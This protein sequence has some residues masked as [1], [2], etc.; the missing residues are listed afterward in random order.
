MKLNQKQ[1]YGIFILVALILIFSIYQFQKED[2][3]KQIVKINQ[4]LFYDNLKITV[5]NINSTSS[6][7]VEGYWQAGF[8]QY[9]DILELSPPQN[10]NYL[11]INISLENLNIDRIYTLNNTLS[12]QIIDENQNSYNISKDNKYIS[13]IEDMTIIPN[14]KETEKIIFETPTGLKHLKLV[15]QSVNQDEPAIIELN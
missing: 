9:P 3:T 6:L 2:I 4:D 7:L 15:I 12:F 1:Y 10:Y 13:N 5:N 8:M 14:K 11:L